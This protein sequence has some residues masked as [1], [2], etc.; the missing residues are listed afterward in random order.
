MLVTG[1]LLI[2][3][4]TGRSLV[5]RITREFEQS[6]R[7]R[8]AAFELARTIMRLQDTIQSTETR[9]KLNERRRVARVVYDAAGYSLTG[10]LVQMGVVRELASGIRDDVADRLAVLEEMARRTITEVRAVVTDLRSREEAPQNWPSRWES[11]CETFA[12]CTGTTVQSEIVTDSNVIPDNVGSGVYRIVQECLANAY[13]HGRSSIVDARVDGTEAG[14]I[15]VPVSDNGLGT[16][17][18]VPGNRLAGIAERVAALGGKVVTV[19]STGK[20]FSVGA[21]IPLEKNTKDD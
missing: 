4:E 3:L 18:L 14:R 21:E 1:V 9:A 2:A 7:A 12:A 16:D 15:L 11:V 19:T 20:G 10:L 8:W 13:R 5:D 17:K 6:E